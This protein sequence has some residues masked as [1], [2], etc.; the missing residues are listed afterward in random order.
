MCESSGP[1]RAEG[2]ERDAYSSGACCGNARPDAL[3]FD[4]GPNAIHT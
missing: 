1:G 2:G 4:D 3:A